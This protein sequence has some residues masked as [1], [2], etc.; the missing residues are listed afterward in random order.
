[1]TV[2]P[3]TASDTK[4]LGDSFSG[5]QSYSNVQDNGVRWSQ[6]SDQ[7]ATSYTQSGD[8]T[9]TTSGDQTSLNQNLTTTQDESDS[10][11]AQEGI[12]GSRTSGTDSALQA[13]DVYSDN[14]S[15]SFHASDSNL[16]GVHT[17]STS[18]NGYDSQVTQQYYSGTYLGDPFTSLLLYN[19]TGW[20]AD[21]SVYGPTG[22]QQN[23]AGNGFTNY[24]ETNNGV[25]DSGSTASSPTSGSSSYSSTYGGGRVAYGLL[26]DLVTANGSVFSGAMSASSPP[27][28]DPSLSGDSAKANQGA[29]P[30][31]DSGVY[32]FFGQEWVM[33]WDARA[34]GFTD[35]IAAYGQ[36][37]KVALAGTV[38]GAIGGATTGAATG[39]ILGGIGGA[40]GGAG[41]GAIPGAVAGAGAGAATGGAWGAAAGFVAAAF[42]SDAEDAFNTGLHYGAVTGIGV[43]GAPATAGMSALAAAGTQ[44][45]VFAGSDAAVQGFEYLAGFRDNIDKTEIAITGL[46]AGGATLAARGLAGIGRNFS[47]SAPQNGAQ[48]GIGE[49][50][51]FY[52]QRGWPGGAGGAPAGG[53]GASAGSALPS[54]GSTLGPSHVFWD[55][56]GWP[57]G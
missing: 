15:H 45:A 47:H 16:G 43:V 57:G 2:I 3:T 31:N 9:A 52:G 56:K 21:S 10:T 27:P 6:T 48:S 28:S 33:P 38:G 51:V 5:S 19:S 12:S 29:A 40:V 39:A 50:H 18:D 25:A 32:R 7:E 53:S 37:G 23:W 22:G 1:V 44:A 13:S 34:G 41:V 46:F 35:T 24:T 55:L 4:Q 36:A 49:S 8:Y 17:G 30:A 26:S 11:N 20:S 54:P 42:A 14:A